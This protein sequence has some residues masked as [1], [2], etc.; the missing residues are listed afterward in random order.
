MKPAVPS[1]AGALARAGEPASV[2]E[3][4]LLIPPACNASS[5]CG[6]MDGRSPKSNPLAVL[7]QVT[8]RG[9]NKT[10]RKRIQ[11]QHGLRPQGRV[12]RTPKIIVA[13]AGPPC[14]QS[15]EDGGRYNRQGCRR[16]T[17]TPDAPSGFSPQSARQ[18]LEPCRKGLVSPVG[19]YRLAASKSA[20]GSSR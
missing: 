6:R 15:P 20:A 14:E 13:R 3:Q 8:V 9:L 2:F 17:E 4:V 12:Q 19:P 1:R 18:A 5:R 10:E 11:P 7:A 16:R